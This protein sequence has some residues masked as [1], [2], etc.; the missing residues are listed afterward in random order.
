MCRYRASP[1]HRRADLRKIDEI[2]P[3]NASVLQTA[4]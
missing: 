3:L 2:T 1:I 4:R